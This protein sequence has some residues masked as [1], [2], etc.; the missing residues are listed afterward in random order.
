M[1][2]YSPPSRREFLL[3]LVVA[4]LTVS[5]LVADDPPSVLTVDE[6][7]RKL[8]AEAPLKLE[9][10]GKTADECRKWQTEFAA[11]LRALLGPHQPPTK[12]KN[13]VPRTALLKDHRR[14]EL[15]LT[16]EGHPPL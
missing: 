7:I 14:L 1:H 3:A 5:A 4:M 13:T 16:A 6:H 11:K 9:F 10:R 12:W 2:R 8:A 15:I